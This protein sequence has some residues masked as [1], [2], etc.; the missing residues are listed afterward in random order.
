METIFSPQSLKYAKGELNAPHPRSTA[1]FAQPAGFGGAKQC[2][3]QPRLRPL[4]RAGLL[5]SS[6]RSTVTL[7]SVVAFSR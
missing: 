4:P 6:L 7:D 3:A 5:I 1:G 2:F